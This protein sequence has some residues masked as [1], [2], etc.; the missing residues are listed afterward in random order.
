MALTMK[1]SILALF[2]PFLYLQ[3]A[4]ICWM[5]CAQVGTEVSALRGTR[6]KRWLHQRNTLTKRM[7][8][9]KVVSHCATSWLVLGQPEATC[10]PLCE[11]GRGVTK[12]LKYR[13]WCTELIRAVTHAV[14]TSYRGEL[15]FIKYRIGKIIVFCL[16][17]YLFTTIAALVGGIKPYLS[18]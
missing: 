15:V 3:R 2:G 17:G 9:M 18:T 16:Y 13:N 14:L 8:S 12:L 4:Q 6:K 1:M 5:A 10:S 7:P 11:C